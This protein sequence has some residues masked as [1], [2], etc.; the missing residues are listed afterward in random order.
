MH[1]S[2]RGLADVDFLE[3]SAFMQKQDYFINSQKLIALAAATFS[4]STP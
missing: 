3:R 1:V 4:E 2:L